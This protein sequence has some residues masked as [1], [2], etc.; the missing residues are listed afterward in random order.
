[1]GGK[2]PSGGRPSRKLMVGWSAAALGA[3]TLAVAGVAQRRLSRVAGL[4]VRRG[5]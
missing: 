2:L 3:A 5:L 1:M 4:A